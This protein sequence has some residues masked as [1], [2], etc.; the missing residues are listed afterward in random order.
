MAAVAEPA[1]E[2]LIVVG[3]GIGGLATALAVAGAGWSVRVLERSPDFREIGAGI[4]LAP[5]ATRLLD[6]WGL[7][8]RLVDVGVLPS[9]LVLR[10]AMSGRELTC[11]HLD[12]KFRETYKGP[13]IVLHRSDLLAALV[14]A[15]R[16]RPTITLEVD[17]TVTEVL[18]DGDGVEVTCSDGSRRTASALVGADGLWS[19]IRRRI[20]DD[21]PICSGFVSY[22]GAVPLEAVS[23]HPSLDDVV[24][25]I[26]PGLHF[27]QYPLRRG[28]LYNQ[29]AVFRSDEYARGEEDW[30]TPEELDRRFASCCPQV[31]AAL[32]ALRRDNRWVM[33]DRE[34]VASWSSGRITLVGDAAHPMLQYLAQGACQAFEDAACLGAALQGRGAD[35]VAAAFGGYSDARSPQASRVQRRARVW[36]DIWHV[37]GVGALLR[38]ELLLQRDPYDYRHIEWLYGPT[39]SCSWRDA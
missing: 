19:A 5:N 16:S 4:Q 11:L 39:A 3:G 33:Y 6:R 14:D 26:G 8:D 22:R 37:D 28:E 9:R 20:V 34:P 25:W 21:E 17:K 29:V 10:S 12:E 30:G 13:Y 32:P 15:C 18:E 2:G 36:G 38:D 23:E 31:V 35:E 24:A 1:E 27:V 7:L